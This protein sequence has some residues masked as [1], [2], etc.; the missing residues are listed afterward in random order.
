MEGGG[1]A[2]TE[3]A[4]AAAARARPG[5]GGRRELRRR[6]RPRKRRVQRTGVAAAA[7]EAAT[8]GGCGC[9]SGSGRASRER[10]RRRRRRRQSMASGDRPRGGGG[11]SVAHVGQVGAGGAAEQGARRRRNRRL[12]WDEEGAEGLVSRAGREGVSKR[13]RRAPGVGTPTR[14]HGGQSGA[15]HPLPAK[16]PGP[17]PAHNTEATS[18]ARTPGSRAPGRTC[19][20]DAAATTPGI[21]RQERGPTRARVGRPAHPGKKEWACDDGWGPRSWRDIRLGSFAWRLETVEPRLCACPV[22]RSSSGKV[23]RRAAAVD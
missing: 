18:G 13:G 21:G 11:A 17:L 16:L 19:G 10:R 4:V 15:N 23:V 22:C 6:P 8:T 14:R 20:H 2:T 1:A 3:A 7:A 5:S 12:A 9:R